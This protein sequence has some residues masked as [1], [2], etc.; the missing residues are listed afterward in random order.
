MSLLLIATRQQEE[1]HHGV[2]WFEGLLKAED[3]AAAVTIAKSLLGE[4]I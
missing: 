3:K 1:G 4:P 2:V